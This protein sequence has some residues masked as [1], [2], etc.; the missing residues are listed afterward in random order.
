MKEL[1][2]AFAA[3][4]LM[5][6][7]TS[8]LAQAPGD[9]MAVCMRPL[10]ERI[11]RNGA[12]VNEAVS[13]AFLREG[14]SRSFQQ[15]FTTADCVG[16]FALGQREVRD[17]DLFLHTDTGIMLVQDVGED[18]HP[19]VRYCGG[20]G[21][22]V[23]VTAR[24][25][26][27]QGEIDLVR[28][29]HAPPSLGDIDTSLGECVV[30]VGGMHS[31]RPNLGEAPPSLAP[32]EALQ[33]AHNTFLAKGFVAIGQTRS[34]S[35]DVGND[36]MIPVPLTRGACYAAVV[37]AEASVQSIEV[38]VLSAVRQPLAFAPD[39]GVSAS[40][41]FCLDDPGTPTLVV[42]TSRGRG[43]FVAEFLQLN[44]RGVLIPPGVDGI[45]RANFVQAMNTMAASGLSGAAR[46]WGFLQA[47]ESMRFPLEL[48]AGVCYGLSMAGAAE[49]FATGFDLVLADD[50]GNVM[51]RDL[52][53]SR[54]PMIYH[55]AISDEH[56]QLLVTR[57]AGAAGRVLLVVGESRAPVT[58]P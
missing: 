4:L 23:Y 42:R 11:S 25:Y 9:S 21:L 24:M 52:N 36:A 49:A 50:E 19:Y 31:A 26:Q 14:E 13:R 54:T 22:S 18:A 58:T 5:L 57:G 28:I 10:R 27:G 6:L 46:A 34:G 12:V 41:V 37:E 15:L 40:V 51:G 17:L 32:R 2:T 29:D 43:S 20:V 55:C 3:A 30:P 39:H 45:G 8:A 53:R 7:A 48:Q 47:G 1:R 56:A 16:F 38:V 33:R 35:L 44:D